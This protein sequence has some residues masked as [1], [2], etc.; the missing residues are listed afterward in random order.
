MQQVLNVKS[1]DDL[2]GHKDYITLTSAKE[3]VVVRHTTLVCKSGYFKLVSDFKDG[4]NKKVKESGR[5]Y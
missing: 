3:G 2:Q 4:K 5:D 1:L